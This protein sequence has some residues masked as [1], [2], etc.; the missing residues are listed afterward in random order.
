MI[1]QILWCPD[2]GRRS[3]ALLGDGGRRRCDAATACGSC[4]VALTLDCDGRT[5]FDRELGLVRDDW[6][7]MRKG[8][9]P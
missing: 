2:H 9:S 5:A 3:T 6:P 8:G 7:E 1:V 4:D